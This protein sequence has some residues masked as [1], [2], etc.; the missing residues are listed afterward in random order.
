MS[1]RVVRA[2]RTFSL[3]LAVNVVSRLAAATDC[4][5]A[6]H[7]SPC[8]DADLSW[9]AAGSARFFGVA[10]ADTPPDRQVALGVAFTYLLRPVQL[11]APSPD[12]EGRD[13][14]VVEQ[15]VDWSPLLAYGLGASAELTLSTPIVLWQTGAGVEGITSRDGPAIGRAAIRDPRVGVGWRW[16]DVGAR[17]APWFASKLRFEVALPFGDERWLVGSTAPVAA[18]SVAAELRAGRFRAGAEVGA[19]FA[20]RVELVDS[21]IGSFARVAI[22]CG[23]ELLGRER[24]SLAAEAWAMPSLVSQPESGGATRVHDARLIPAEWLFS[25]R[26]VPAPGLQL[27]LGGGTAIPLSS[28]TRSDASDA[29][30]AFAGVGAAR[31]R[32]VLSVR[33]VPQTEAAA[34]R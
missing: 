10:S 15:R 33:W 26:S 19:R 14:R 2:L 34:H 27:Q 4:A 25:V 16:L 28:A 5:P 32:V 11:N 18:P 21:A 17:A 7:A 12:P 20:R 6:G 22:G 30:S 1:R 3:T 31:V 23:F 24:L 9:L 29:A 13:V 8:F